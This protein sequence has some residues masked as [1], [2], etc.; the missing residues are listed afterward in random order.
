M[1]SSSAAITPTST[2][3]ILPRSPYR[4]VPTPNSSGAARTSPQTKSEPISLRTPTSD[5]H[6][7][8]ASPVVPVAPFRVAPF[9]AAPALHRLNGG[10]ACLE[11]LDGRLGARWPTADPTQLGVDL[12]VRQ[13]RPMMV[14]RDERVETFAQQDAPFGRASRF[15]LSAVR[16]VRA[17]LRRGELF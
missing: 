16:F 6:T 13:L 12:S 14:C 7:R 10:D 1:S 9:R 15:S 11:L 5:I 3:R 4:L 2:R 8:R 17:F